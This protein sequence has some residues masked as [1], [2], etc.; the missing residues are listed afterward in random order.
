M[1]MLAAIGF[2]M[3]EY[4]LLGPMLLHDERDSQVGLRL[5]GFSGS[6]MGSGWSCALREV[7]KIG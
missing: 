6:V 2:D 5:R 3:L 7:N 4:A 1:R